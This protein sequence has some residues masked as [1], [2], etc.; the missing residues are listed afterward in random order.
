MPK[1]Y[2]TLKTLLLQIRDDAV[3][4]QEELDEFIRFSGLQPEQIEV[5]NVFATPQFD[6]SLL[7]G[8]DALFVGGSS[9]AS[10][11]QPEKY[12]FVEPSKQLIY[13]YWQRGTPVFASCFGFQLA[14]EAMGG[15]VIVDPAQ[16]EIGIL[17]MR[18]TSAAFCDRLFQDVPD[19][20]WAVVGHKERALTL[21]SSAILLASTEKCLYHA[22][23][24]AGKP[25]YAFQ[26]HPE[27]DAADF[28]AR[29]HRYCDRY[30]DDPS[31][32]KKMLGEPRDTAIAN[33]LI[34][35]FVE[36][37]ALDP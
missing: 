14:V 18:L 31:N 17:P 35:K 33:S 29:I 25:F 26:F 23:R 4:E 3:T 9:D 22:F 7:S 19:T 1:C 10:V 24:M 15:K 13:D 11:T 32:L 6:P 37:I 12:P 8:Y 34:R 21:P 30:L 27:V 2:Q 28:F 5:L 36:R 16:M 20:F